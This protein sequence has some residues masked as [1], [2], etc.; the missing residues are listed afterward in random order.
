V[1]PKNRSSPKT[2]LVEVFAASLKA[3]RVEK[4]LTQEALADLA[5]LHRT[6]VGSVERGERNVTLESVERLARA[7]DVSPSDLLRGRG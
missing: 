1:V 2:P 3:H 7:L 5:G 6:Y 4:G